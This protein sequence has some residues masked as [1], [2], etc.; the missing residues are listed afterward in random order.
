MLESDYSSDDSCE[1]TIK[2]APCYRV[3]QSIL[4]FVSDFRSYAIICV[5]YRLARKRVNQVTSLR[6]RRS[7]AVLVKPAC[8]LEIPVDA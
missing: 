6:A 3:L 1:D 5:S 2:Y 8:T 4:I 7:L